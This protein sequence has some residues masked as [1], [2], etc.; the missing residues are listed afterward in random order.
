MNIVLASHNKNKL[1]E[2]SA[3]LSEAFRD[4]EDVTV[5]SMTDVG[6]LDEAEETGAT[7]LENAIIK[8]KDGARSG[9]IAVADDSGLSVDALGGAPGIYSARYAGEDA[10]DKKNNDKLLAALAKEPYRQAKFVCCIACVFPRG[11]LPIVARGETYGEIL[12]CPRGENGF[13]YDP[14]FWV[15]E[16]GKTFAELSPDE[17]NAISHRG[18]A[19]VKFANLLAERRLIVGKDNL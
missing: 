8:A 14:L 17:K 12:V 1:R 5:L 15:D 11:G 2:L 4:R 3:L 9:Y 13:G 10:D 7:F 6:L 19:T 16:L 18:R